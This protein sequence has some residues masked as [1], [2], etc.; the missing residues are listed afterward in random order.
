[1]H[2]LSFKCAI[3]LMKILHLSD[4]HLGH[5]CY[6]NLRRQAAFRKNFTEVHEGG[7]NDTIANLNPD[8]ILVAGD[9]FDNSSPTY[10]DM[11]ILRNWV[12]FWQCPVIGITGNHEKLPES[13][14]QASEYFG[15]QK[16]GVYGDLKIVCAN[17]MYRSV[18]RNF[19]D[20]VEECDILMLHQSMCGFLASIMKPEIDEETARKLAD[21]CSYLALGDLHIHNRMKI[22]NCI[23]AYP[24][25]IDFL[26][27][28]ESH[29]KFGAWLIEEKNGG[30]SSK[31]IQLQPYQ[32]TTIVDVKTEEDFA[33]LHKSIDCAENDF[34]VIKAEEHPTLYPQTELLLNNKRYE[35]EQ[36]CFHITPVSTEDG[37]DSTELEAN[38]NFDEDFMNIIRKDNTV[39][40]EDKKLASDL[41]TTG[42]T[43]QMQALL[44]QDLKELKERE[45]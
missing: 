18:L 37:E 20:T 34:F 1:M 6:G 13:F 32:K 22:D 16:P 9:L 26:R 41:W 38:S 3:L 28:G 12:S 8:A 36:F 4:L 21:K 29:N 5:R 19:A 14:M 24:G 42:S 2:I 33:K 30:L 40:E 31:S 17:H 10:D 39:E 11:D 43:K 25:P 35:C 23:A 45:D 15:I 7:L 27:I 44:A